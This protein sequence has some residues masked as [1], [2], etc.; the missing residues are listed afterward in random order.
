MITLLDH[1]AEELPLL[2][3]QGLEGDALYREGEGAYCV[4]GAYLM[5]HGIR[6]ARNRDRSGTVLRITRVEGE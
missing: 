1:A 2:R 3:L 4:S 5:Q 6:T